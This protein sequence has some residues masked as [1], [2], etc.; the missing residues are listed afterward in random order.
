M[1]RSANIEWSG[2]SDD[3]LGRINLRDGHLSNSRFSSKGRFGEGAG[4]NPE[5][6]LAAAHG[7]CFSMALTY[8]MGE[9]GIVPERIRTDASVQLD[10]KAKTVTIAAIHL[11]V[12]AKV[13]QGSEA[14]AMAAAMVAKDS[15]PLSRLLKADVTMDFA[16]ER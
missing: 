14:G 15:C 8:E 3:G 9:A 1:K 6:L 13:A 2:S 16:I 12:R 4:T 5:E 11:T 7:A 10:R